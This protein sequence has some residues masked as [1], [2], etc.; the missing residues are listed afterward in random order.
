MNSAKGATT[1]W[2]GE[3][4]RQ[5]LKNEDKVGGAHARGPRECDL[6]QGTTDDS[7]KQGRVVRE[8]RK[9]A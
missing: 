6:K 7:A 2:H 8:T 5:V 9:L 3:L 1:S 4:D